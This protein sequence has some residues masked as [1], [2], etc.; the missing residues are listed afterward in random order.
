MSEQPL[1]SPDD[2]SAAPSAGFASTVI[3]N[4]IDPEHLGSASLSPTGEFAAGSY[5]SF[6][7]VYTAGKYGIDDSGSLRICFRFA[8]DQTRPQFENPEGP[9]YTIIEASN[10]AVLEHRYDPKGNVRPWDRTLYIKVVHGFLKEGDTISIRFGVTD[11]GSPGMRLQTFCEDSFEFHVLVDPIATFTYQPLPEQ[12]KI[13][14]V[15]GERERFLAV[16]PTLRRAG[17]TFALKFK[18]E[19][20]WGNPSD[21]GGVGFTLRANVPVS[22]LPET[23]SLPDGSFSAEIPGLSVAEAGDLVIELLDQAGNAVTETN[24]LR[25]VEDADRIHYWA[26]LHGQSEETIG[27]GD[28]G[29]YFAFAR[30]RAF[31]DAT[32]H[33]GNDFQITNRFW[34]RLDELSARFE[35]DGKFVV[36]PGY[37]WSGNTGLGG[38]RNVYF[39]E[40]GRQIR[41]SSHALVEDRSDIAT[42]CSTANDLFEALAANREWDVVV[43]AHCGGRYA[44]VKMAHDGRFEKS[45]EIHSSWGTFEWLLH[46]A[47]EMGYR[48]GIV[49]NSDGHKGRPGASYPGA[50]LFGAVGGLT[51]LITGELTRSSVLD[52]LRKRHHYATTGGPN[53]RMYIDV[54]AAFS[55]DATIYH[56]DPAIGPAEGRPGRSAIMGDIVHLPD[57]TAEI[58]VD[59]HAPCAIERADIFNGL[60]HVE[61][62]RPYGSDELGNRIR[63]LWE[64]AEYRGRFRQVI[65][66]GSAL[67]SDNRIEAAAPINFFNP[68]KTLD[69]RGDNGLE[70]KALTTGNIG[71]FDVWLADPYG[72]TLKLET[73]LVQCGIPVEEIGFEDEIFD[74]SGVLPRYLK[75]YR[76]P[77]EN[78][79]RR[80]TFKRTI[81]LKDDGDNPIYIRLTQEDGT[82]AWTS[83][84]YIYR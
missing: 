6:T 40:E 39:S 84:I 31:V 44:D 61:T 10:N 2:A 51:C 25:I 18:G 78:P 69:R 30:D 62:I 13:K 59:I 49:A 34:R 82:L 43:F 20:R 42:D 65:W 68:D 9:N 45:M 21:K 16:I 28:A 79:H 23:V 24:P 22:G 38:D 26:D 67:V 36:L 27:T 75:V 57:G 55:R 48:T 80:M 50:S 37:E 81:G 64:G 3:R 17:E 46:D 1:G 29:D 72:G 58:D 70:W 54:S 8:S 71:G 63:V 35:E 76:L 52:C 19:D 12:P 60:D 56:D 11:H 77:A 32:G 14:I 5:Q 15:P 73:P 66:D 4:P 53:G 41:R 7:L 33:Q 83:P 74:R 47:L